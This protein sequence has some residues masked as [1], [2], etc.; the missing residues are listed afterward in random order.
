[1]THTPPG[2]TVRLGAPVDRSQETYRAAPYESRRVPPSG[3]VSP[4]GRSAYPAPS[5]GAKI[6][7]LGGAAI[8]AAAL[9]AGGVLAVRKIADMVSGNDRLDRRADDAAER[10]RERVYDDAR[11]QPR[12]KPRASGHDHAAPASSR[13]D[14][15][16]APRRA[17][18]PR[19]QNFVEDVEQTA[20]RLNGGILGVIGSIGAAITGFRTV[21]AQAEGVVREFH[22]TADSIR[23]FLDEN[24]ERARR[25]AAQS[26]QARADGHGAAPDPAHSTAGGRD[27][28]D[29]RASADPRTHRL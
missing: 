3:K 29:T 8:A 24:A 27:A 23:H 16:P 12:A 20:Q 14:R 19:R 15:A 21:A 13:T 11:G 2:P 9:T 22:A 28:A 4:D 17:P 6:V 5:T 18:P 1:M 10:A 7:T 25:R 26:A